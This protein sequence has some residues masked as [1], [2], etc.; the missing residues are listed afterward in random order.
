MIEV[1]EHLTGEGA[2]PYRRWVGGLNPPAQ[3]RVVRAIEQMGKGNLSNARGVGGG[4]H[5]FRIHFGP[6]YRVYFGREG[7]AL[8]ILLGGGVKARQQRDI[9]MAR[10]LWADYKRKK[11]PEA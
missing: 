5:E 1:R 9:E 6:G 3:A 4:V 2:S 10:R 8:I 11:R 7:D